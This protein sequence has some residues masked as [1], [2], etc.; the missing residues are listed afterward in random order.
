MSM[1]QCVLK[2]PFFRVQEG[3]TSHADFLSKCV[4]KVPRGWL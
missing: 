2:S 4:N 1:C 3:H